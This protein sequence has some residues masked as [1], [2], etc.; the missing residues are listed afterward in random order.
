MMLSR[1]RRMV[2]SGRRGIYARYC[3]RKKSAIQH[4]VFEASTGVLENEAVGEYTTRYCGE[5]E[6]VMQD[7][8]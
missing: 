5:V 6:S 2:Q 4:L 1:L 3:I 7:T 8:A